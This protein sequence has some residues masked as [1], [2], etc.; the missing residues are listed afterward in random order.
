MHEPAKRLLLRLAQGV[1]VVWGAFTVSFIVLYLIPG[2]SVSVLLGGDGGTY[3]D[4]AEQEALRASLGLDRPFLLQYFDVLQQYLRLDLGESVRYGAPVT[5]LLAEAIPSTIALTLAAMALAIVFGIAFAVLV[6]FRPRSGAARLFRILPAFG[7]AVPTFWIAL[8]LLQLFSFRW[9]LFP[10]AGDDGWR[11][12]VLPAV[13]IAV[14]Y[15]SLIAQVTIDGI[16]RSRGELYVETAVAKGVSSARVHL[17]HVLPSSLLPTISVIGVNFGTLLAG[18]VV[19]ETIFS[20][21]GIGALMQSSVLQRDL[22]LVQ[23]IIVVTAVAFVLVNL[24]TDSVYPIVDPRVRA[25]R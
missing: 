4:P 7:T 16:A 21:Q 3:V 22:P 24:V 8:I 6:T 19:S 11:S 25:S 15:A 9:S 13:T 20:R 17:R 18:A 2:D 14:P 1:L 10:V 5:Q 12:L 23:A